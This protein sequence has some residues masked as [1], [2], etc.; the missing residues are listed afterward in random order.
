MGNNLPR[1]RLTFLA[2]SCRRPSVD[3][4]GYAIYSEKLSC[5]G[6]P[7]RTRLDRMRTILFIGWYD[8]SLVWAKAPLGCIQREMGTKNHVSQTDH[9]VP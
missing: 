1:Q 4:P 3:R 7:R 5:G 6:T 9:P 8:T 2:V